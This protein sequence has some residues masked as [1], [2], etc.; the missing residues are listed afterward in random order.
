[1]TPTRIEAG[2][3][4]RFRRITSSR[5]VPADPG[6]NGE[7][8]MTQPEPIAVAIN[9]AVRLCGIGRSSIYEA[10]RRGDLPIRKSGRRTLL[11][12]EDLRQWLA[13]LPAPRGSEV[14]RER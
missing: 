11:L 7:N 14:R 5:C 4:R 6:V 13:G 3:F 12:M 1:L 2:F 8:D 9:E 10:V